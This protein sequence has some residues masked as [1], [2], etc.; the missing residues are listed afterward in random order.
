MR[1]DSTTDQDNSNE[2]LEKIDAALA[3]LNP[4]DRTA[5]AMRYLQ[6]CPMSEV[7]QALG[8]AEEAAKK[9]VSR[10]LERLRILL[11]HL[12]RPLSI[13][14][15]AGAL[16][17]TTFPSPL[18]A[19]FGRHRHHHS[20]FN[21]SHISH[22]NRRHDD[23]SSRLMENRCRRGDPAISR[24]CRHTTAIPIDQSNL[25][26]SRNGRRRAGID[27]NNKTFFPNLD[28]HRR[29]TRR[30]PF[31]QSAQMSICSVIR[32]HPTS[33]LSRNG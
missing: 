33:L 5:I 6:Q 15:L 22:R 20:H 19:D 31:Q 18:S 10:A 23:S 1:S 13:A 32:P 14:A 16:E 2:L 30:L 28:R 8:L 9:R 27:I 17:Q 24:C 4:K 11:A 3:A 21:H 25:R 12:R 7:A 29:S 26:R